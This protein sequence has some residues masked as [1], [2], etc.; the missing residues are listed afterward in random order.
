MMI[1]LYGIYLRIIAN[2]RY[3]KIQII[4]WKNRKILETLFPAISRLGIDCP[5]EYI[6]LMLTELCHLYLNIKIFREL[7]YVL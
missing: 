6:N 3:N 5:F 1:F 4:A 7:I 2:Q